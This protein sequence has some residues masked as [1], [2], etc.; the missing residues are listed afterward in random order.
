MIKLHGM[1][2]VNIVSEELTA[3]IIMAKILLSEVKDTFSC[4]IKTH[5]PCQ[6]LLDLQ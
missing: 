6:F 5:S 3:S 1:K 4:K 2:N